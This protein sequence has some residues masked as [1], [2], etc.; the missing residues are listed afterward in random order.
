MRIRRVIEPAV[1]WGA[2]GVFAVFML[3]FAVG[4]LFSASLSWYPGGS[5][6]VSIRVERGVLYTGVAPD[7]PVATPPGL[8]HANYGYGMQSLR[9]WH[10]PWFEKR[11][12]LHGANLWTLA[13]PIWCVTLLFASMTL[14][15][16]WCRGRSALNRCRCGY[17]LV[18]LAATK[19]PECGREITRT[20]VPPIAAGGA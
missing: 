13:V 16:W 2:T 12:M 9:W 11:T 6:W 3:V 7:L 1:R 5:L 17:S 4:V 10:W 18:G 8:S 14:A 20:Q 19:C 15:L